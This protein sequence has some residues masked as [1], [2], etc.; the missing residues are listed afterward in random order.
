MLQTRENACFNLQ[1]VLRPLLATS[2]L[3][4][5]AI[6]CTPVNSFAATP[7]TLTYEGSAYGTSA[8]VGSTILIGQTAPVTLGGV[9]GT[10]QQPVMVTG[11]SV[12]ITL[13]PL[14][15]GGATNTNASSSLDT[16]QAVADTT[17]ISLL[18]GLISAQEIKAVTTT[19]IDSSGVLHVSTSGSNF[20]NLVIL[21][22]VYNGTVPANTRITLPLL[23]YVVLNEQTSSVGTSTA[24]LAINMVHVHVTGFNLLGIQVGTEIIV[25]SA[26]SGIINVFAPAIITGGSFATQV[27]GP[28][29]TSAA[30]APESLPC[31]GTGGTV[32]TNMLTGLNLTGI[33][34]SGTVTDTA[35]SSLGSLGSSGVTTS[36]VQ[37]LNL[38]SGLVS[39]SVIRAQTN[40]FINGSLHYLISGS[41]QFTS[42][43][44]AGHPEINDNVPANTTVP[45]AG[46]GTLYLYRI[47]NN[48]PSPHSVEVRMV[49]LVVTQTNLL[50]LPI[51]LDI[52]VGDANQQLVGYQLP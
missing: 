51:G 25:S 18:G 30:T 21:G 8:F 48:F 17:T 3:L 5:L 43:S 44:V 46:L 32:L 11:N 2:I 15:S 41:G 50:G 10:P 35:E 38:L 26:T 49:E 29:L 13:P 4:A 36:T 45:I 14:V 7:E 19:T 34:T 23:G 22:H 27:A 28:P 47:I 16:A 24:S 12:G 31:L 39:A 42:L 52:I 40:T 20:N 9:C 37:N 33:L 6:L 1:L